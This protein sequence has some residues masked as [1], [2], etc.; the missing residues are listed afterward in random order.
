MEGRK[1]LYGVMKNKKFESNIGTIKNIDSCILIVSNQKTMLRWDI[2]IKNCY[3][4]KEE[5]L[6]MLQ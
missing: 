6:Q 4:G 2:K 1:L 3:W 5:N